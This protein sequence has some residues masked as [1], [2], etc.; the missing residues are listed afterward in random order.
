MSLAMPQADVQAVYD[1]CNAVKYNLSTDVIHA[2]FKTYP[3]GEG[4]VMYACLMCMMIATCSKE[5]AC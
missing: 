3:T 4:E 2:I 5:E 1:G